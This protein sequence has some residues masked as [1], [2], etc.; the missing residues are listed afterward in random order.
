MEQAATS[1]ASLA[2]L[3]VSYSSRLTDAGIAAI[4]NA[5]G[6]TLGS[7][8]AEDVPHLTDAGLTAMGSA[9]SALRRCQLDYCKEITAAGV[10]QLKGCPGLEYLSLD[11][12]EK[13]GNDL[14]EV[15]ADGFVALKKLNL[16][17][18][19]AIGSLSAEA[20]N[21]IKVSLEARGVQVVLND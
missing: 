9:A 15:L 4:F 6:A 21:S 13:L 3:S 8:T 16:G 7:F 1:L 14:E 11:A 17:D 20:A 10:A 18:I 12:C 2:S 19:V 5:R